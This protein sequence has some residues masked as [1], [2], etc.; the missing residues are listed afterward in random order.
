MIYNIALPFKEQRSQSIFGLNLIRVSDV[1][2]RRI[3]N[4]KKAANVSQ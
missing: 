4:V 3:I 1:D 2:T